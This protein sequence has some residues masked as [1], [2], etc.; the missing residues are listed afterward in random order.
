MHGV[1]ITWCS[2]LHPPLPTASRQLK[3]KWGFRMTARYEM[4]ADLLAA[5]VRP[6][7]EPQIV[8]DPS[9]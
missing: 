4:Y 9:L 7:Y 2:P 1:C 8:K 3:D 5:Y 6:D